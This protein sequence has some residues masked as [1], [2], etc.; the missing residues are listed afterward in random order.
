LAIFSA[1]AYVFVQW[2]HSRRLPSLLLLGLLGFMQ[3]LTRYDGWFVVVVEGL[4]LGIYELAVVRSTIAQTFGKLFAFALPI[5]FGVGLWFLWNYLIFGDPLY[6]LFGPYSAH[7]Q[8]AAI[9]ARSGLITD[10]HWLVS[11]RA[12][13]LAMLSN[14]GWISFALALVGAALYLACKAPVLSGISRVLIGVFLM[15]PILFNIIAL[16]LGFSIINLPA[17]GWHPGLSSDS[18]YFNVR[19]GLMALPF[20][21]VF[22]GVLAS[23]VQKFSVPILVALCL[24]QQVFL[25]HGGLISYVDG[26]QGSSTYVNSDLSDYLQQHVRR[27]DKLLMSTA[28]FNA[29]AFRSGVDLA[30]LVYEGNT[31]E[32]QQALIA[33]QLHSEWVVTSNGKTGDPAYNSFIDAGAGHAA[34]SSYFKLAY[35][36]LHGNIY[37]RRLDSELYVERQGLALHIGSEG[38]TP[39]GVNSYDL[40]Y[41]ND[42]EIRQTF[43]EL[44]VAHVNTVRFWLFGDGMPNGV[45]PHAGIL[46]EATLRKADLII[47]LAQAHHM[48]LI[49]VLVNNWSDYGGRA[50]YLTWL[51]MPSDR[52]DAF[53]T[54]KAAQSLYQNYVNHILTRVNTLSGS[55][56]AEE[57]S[58]LA[59]DLMNEPRAEDALALKNWTRVMAAYVRSKDMNHL[60][61]VGSEQVYASTAAVTTDNCSL[62]VIDLCSVHVYPYLSDEP[63]YQSLE[64]LR[65]AMQEQARIAQ[66]LGKPILLGELGVSKTDQ[67]FGKS[68]IVTLKD[69][70]GFAKADRYA[71]M[72]I[73]NWSVIPDTSYGFSPTGIFSTTALKELLYPF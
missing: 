61:M 28:Y 14:I 53:Y 12:Y 5:V 17:L 45:Q 11:F 46:N 49:P 66:L 38:F 39:K 36:G 22:I 40:L 55:T 2:L 51:G 3:V 43:D 33:P 41:R 65:S 67:P 21:G 6:F 25:Y 35:R 69:L 31:S 57:P 1:N 24:I 27:T 26:T 42:G 70:V 37:K 73:W 59:W 19:Y 20:V 47:S 13:G 18:N 15:S 34:F 29:V 7:A 64:K 62:E 52:P 68:P 71:G 50:Q 63:H 44:Q 54:S 60:L 32:W 72:L 58:I 56:Y 30:Q 9:A 23:Q 10:H 16:Y 4:L 48:K 8:Q